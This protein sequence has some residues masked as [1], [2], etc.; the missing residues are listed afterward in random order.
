VIP[1]DGTS[2]LSLESNLVGKTISLEKWKM[3]EGDL[4]IEMAVDMTGQKH[5]NYFNPA[6]K[7]LS[8]YSSLIQQS[9]PFYACL[10]FDI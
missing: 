9:I 3:N 6:F 8:M 1:Y 2:F 10:L 4:N 5:S 7:S